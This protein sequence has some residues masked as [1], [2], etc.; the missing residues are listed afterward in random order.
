MFISFSSLS[1]NDSHID[2]H[3]S[4]PW[5]ATTFN[6]TYELPQF[7]VYFQVYSLS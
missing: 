4:P 2:A 1:Y 3:G 6:L 5:L 7:A